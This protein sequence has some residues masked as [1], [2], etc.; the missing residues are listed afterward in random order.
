MLRKAIVSGSRVS[1]ISRGLVDGEGC[2]RAPGE[3]GEV[4]AL[5]GGTAQRGVVAVSFERPGPAWIIPIRFLE[6]VD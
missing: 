4:V 1:V 6:R 3:I 5:S 2:G